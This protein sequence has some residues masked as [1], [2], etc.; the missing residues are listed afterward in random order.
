M[1]LSLQVMAAPVRLRQT[2]RRALT[3]FPK[4][5]G[6]VAAESGRSQN[7]F[8]IS[9]QTAVAN[10]QE[11]FTRL[12]SQFLITKKMAEAVERAWPLEEGATMFNILNTYTGAAQDGALDVEESMHL[13]RVGGQTLSMVRQ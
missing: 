7:Q 8:M 5:M 1:A 2:S 12:N 11:T 3:E 13:E 10:P 6:Q 9:T 4:L